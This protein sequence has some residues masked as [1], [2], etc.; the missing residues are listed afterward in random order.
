MAA[1]AAGRTLTESH[2]LLQ[3]RLSLVTN[4]RLLE[5]WQLLDVARIDA[6]SG[7]WLATT[8]AIVGQQ[9]LVSAEI[10][11]AYLRQFRAVELETDPDA[12]TAPPLPAIDLEAVATSLSVQGPI[13][14][15]SLMATG[16]PL[17]SIAERAAMSSAAAGT[18]HSLNGGRD[19]IVAS[20][21]A[22]PDAH[23]VRRVTSPGC[24]SFCALLAS[25]SYHGVTTAAT[26][27]FADGTWRPT[28]KVH[29]NC[30]CQPET[31]Y[32]TGPQDATRQAREFAALYE[33]S[34]AGVRGGSKGKQNAFRRA[35]E[36]Q[37]S[38]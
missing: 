30:H 10:A 2:R 28:F 6:T 1:T 31:A 29:D 12:F 13:R 36:A 27:R 17:T 25:R 33:E 14:I 23:G 19:L 37:R 8:T 7:R 35:L 15:K 3:A 21:A 22:D 18:R 16:E 34:T 26:G 38:T 20:S 5:A 4:S 11:R 32:T 9:R 24:C